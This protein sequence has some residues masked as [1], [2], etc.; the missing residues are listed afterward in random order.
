MISDKKDKK[1]V[2]LAILLLVSLGFNLYNLKN[3]D[4]SNEEKS[5]V[6]R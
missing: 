3:N 1:I 2:L 6:M 4:S 5:K